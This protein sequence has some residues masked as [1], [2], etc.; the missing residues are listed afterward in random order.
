M[1]SNWYTTKKDNTNKKQNKDTTKTR[2]AKK[3]PVTY[4][5]MAASPQTKL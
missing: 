2:E 4:A 1:E 5:Q 3:M